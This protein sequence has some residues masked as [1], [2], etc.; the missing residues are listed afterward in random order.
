[1]NR[2]LQH[3][4][5][6]RFSAMGD[7]ALIAP[8]VKSF[9]EAYSD[10]RITIASRPKF[11]VFFDNSNPNV[12]FFPADVDKTYVGLPGIVKL[13]GHLRKL[14]PTVVIDLHDHLRSR[15][16]CFL[17]RLLGVPVVRFNKGRKEKKL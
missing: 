2:E 5:V 10:H 17:F 14:N 8:M 15:L 6:L 11:S 12:K 3:I 1:M 4:L 7:V 13:F 16:L 9:Q